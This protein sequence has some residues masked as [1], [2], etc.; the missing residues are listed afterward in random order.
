MST[1]VTLVARHQHDLDAGDAMTRWPRELNDAMDNVTAM[2]LGEIARECGGARPDVG[3]SI[4]RG[5]ILARRLREE[6]FW[7]GLKPN[8]RES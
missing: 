1:P 5:L 3:D 8:E 7:L 2:R 6:G 4:D